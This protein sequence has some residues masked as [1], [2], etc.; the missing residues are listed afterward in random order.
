MNIMKSRKTGSFSPVK[1]IDPAMV[2]NAKDVRESR[3]VLMTYNN[4]PT[5]SKAVMPDCIL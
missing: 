1:K 3:D 4:E 2:F 5:F